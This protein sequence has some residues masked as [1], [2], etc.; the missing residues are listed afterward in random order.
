MA[1]INGTNASETLKGFDFVNDT[2]SGLGG[3]DHIFG[4]SGNDALNGNDGNDTLVGGA[5]NDFL[6]GGNGIDTLLGGGGQD[7]LTGGAGVNTFRYAFASETKV[8]FSNHDIIT[9]F[10][11]GI[12]KINL[13]S[14]D[15]VP[16]VAGNQAFRFAG[17]GPFAF[18]G[19][20]EVSFA[21]GNTFILGNT[22]TDI[23]P[24]FE[25]QLNGLHTISATD[26]I[27]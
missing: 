2:I 7:V 6:N 11:H 19:D 3:D 22:D 25:I 9:D 23:Q 12:D 15:A 24:E 18:E 21:N 13:S 17:T 26:F 16:D 8:G 20:I 1:I 14:I 4:L 27:L 10:V 5:G